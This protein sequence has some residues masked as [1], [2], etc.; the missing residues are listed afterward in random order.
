MI[1]Q[2]IKDGTL[3]EALAFKLIEVLVDFK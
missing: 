2:N 3:T 1:N